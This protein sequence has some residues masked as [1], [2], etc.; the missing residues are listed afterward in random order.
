MALFLSTLQHLSAA[1]HTC[2]KQINYTDQ[3][4]VTRTVFGTALCHATNTGMWHMGPS[5]T[6]HN[7]NI[8]RGHQALGSDPK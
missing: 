8:H 2:L 5:Q 7:L 3:I 1:L 4:V 6:P